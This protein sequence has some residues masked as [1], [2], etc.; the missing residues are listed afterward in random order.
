MA[1]MQLMETRKRTKPKPKPAVPKIVNPMTENQLSS[2]FKLSNLQSIKS[3]GKPNLIAL[4]NYELETNYIYHSVPKK[5]IGAYLLAKVSNW[6]AYNLIKGKANIF[7]EGGFVGTTNI[8]PE[9]T[10]DEILISMGRD[11]DIIVQRKVSTNFVSSKVIAANKRESLGY[12]IIVKNK[13][14]VP[15]KIEIL[16]QI[17]LSK[18]STIEVALEEK[19]SAVYAKKIGRLLW[20]WEIGAGETQ[21]E[22]FSY[23]VKYP[24][25]ETIVGLK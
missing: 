7:F 18:N 8:N 12:D 13:K 4:T 1:T 11:N 15:I 10:A 24:K 23:T 5:D 21:A 20:T 16:D 25:K 3:D 22:A 9:I 14:S 6:T 19:G 17:P 2:E